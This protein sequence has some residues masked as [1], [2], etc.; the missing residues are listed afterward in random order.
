MNITYDELT[1]TNIYNRIVDTME[2]Y[3][4]AELKI[5][6]K[7]VRHGWG[8]GSSNKNKTWCL[9]LTALENGFTSENGHKFSGTGYGRKTISTAL[10]SL[11]KRGVIFLQDTIK[12]GRVWGIVPEAIMGGGKNYHSAIVKITTHKVYNNK[13]KETNVS[14]QPPSESEPAQK[15]EPKP[16]PKPDPKPVASEQAE[17]DEKPLSAFDLWTWFDENHRYKIKSSTFGKNI[18]HM[19]LGTSTKK[20]YQMK[21]FIEQPVTIA[22]M[23]A[24]YAWYRKQYKGM[25][26]P[27]SYKK[28]ANH[29]LLYR[30]EM[31]DNN[32]APA[33]YAKQHAQ[34]NELLHFLQQNAESPSE[35]AAR[36][37]KGVPS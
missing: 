37:T 31:K 34:T 1:I 24:F 8:F 15:T 3:K 6:L 12:W 20:D 33:D 9:S 27:T 2:Q 35:I 23:T 19:L 26:Y 10:S 7:I 16:D 25:D 21:E 28:L 5:L 11:E 4:P 18:A 14:L 29:I 13:V 30:D 22:E 32:A 36:L 17:P